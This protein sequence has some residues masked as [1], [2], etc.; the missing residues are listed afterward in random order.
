[1]S[2][3][4]YFDYAASTPCD[5]LVIEAMKP[6]WAETFGNPHSRSHEFGWN[7]ENAI[8]K[9]RKQ[10]ADLINAD[11]SE[12]IFTSGA[13]ESNNLAI[14]GF[15]KH[16]MVKE[17][18]QGKKIL[19]IKSEHKCVI[20]T[21]RSL[22]QEGFEVVFLPI[23]SNGLVDLEELK[24]EIDNACLVSI[25]YINNE[26]GVI[27]DIPQISKI[28][29]EKKVTLHVDAAQAF[30]KIPINARDVDLMSISGHK[31]YGPKGIGALFVSKKPRVRILPLISGGGQERGMR[32]GTLATPLC[33]G[34]G[35]AAEVAS[36]RMQADYD[37]AKK[38]HDMVYSQVVESMDHVFINGAL[39][40][41]IPHIIN[42]SIPYV[43]GESLMMRMGGF[44]LASGSA[45][46]SK[47]LEPSHVIKAMN[48]DDHDLAH[49]SIRVC[50]GRNTR[51][52]DVKNLI[53]AFKKH[54]I[55]L[56]DLSPLWDM[57]QKGIDLKSINWKAH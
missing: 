31:I 12:I 53:A 7:S 46:T 38:L 3:V 49:S 17:K 39:D 57:V 10:I 30:G 15:I 20:E 32:S 40:S 33:V 4:K 16:P 25:S 36:N 23:H 19:S 29:R 37:K 9:A 21:L 28:C 51:E 43:E 55:E 13:T 6:Y 26:T 44:A 2:D 45:C 8:E 11:A 41:K 24:K 1:M 34:L 14:K 48:P 35:A 56:R 18:V 22:E 42:I 5:D 52:E 50:F 27:Q 54:I 47:S